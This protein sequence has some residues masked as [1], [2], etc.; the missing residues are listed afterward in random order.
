MANQMVEDIRCSVYSAICILSNIEYNCSGN[1]K[2][3]NYLVNNKRFMN[4]INRLKLEKISNSI[5]KYFT[6][7]LGERYF[8][9]TDIGNIKIAPKVIGKLDLQEFCKIFKIEYIEDKI[10]QN[11][12]NIKY[13]ILTNYNQIIKSYHKNIFNKNTICIIFPKIL[14]NNFNHNIY[15]FDNFDF[16]YNLDKKSIQFTQNLNKWNISNTIK[17]YNHTLGHFMIT[18]KVEFKFNLYDYI[19]ILDKLN[20]VNDFLQLE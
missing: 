3:I 2:L 18:N 16:D 15:V 4:I 7:N 12:L 17:Y 13:Y 6:N 5:N 11:I 14:Y 1:E 9:L 10:D 8:V 19:E 20:F